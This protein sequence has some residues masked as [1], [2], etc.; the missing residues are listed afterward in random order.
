[1]KRLVNLARRPRKQNQPVARRNFVHLESVTLKPCN[2]LRNVASARP[3]PRAKLRRR[4]PLMKH[5]RMRIML[6]LHQRIQIRLP[7]R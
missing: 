3:K 2:N 5:R 4:Q 6:R 7:L 1:M